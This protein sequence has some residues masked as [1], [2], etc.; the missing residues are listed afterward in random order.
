M[1]FTPFMNGMYGESYYFMK[2]LLK[3][4]FFQLSYLLIVYKNFV[5]IIQV[6]KLE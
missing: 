3:Q 4:D 2:Y 1:L 6:P 5:R